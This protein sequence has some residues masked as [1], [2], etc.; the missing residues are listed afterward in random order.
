MVVVRLTLVGRGGTCGPIVAGRL[1]ENP[2]ATVLILEAGKDSADMDN[3]DMA[4][5]CVFNSLPNIHGLPADNAFTI[6]QLDHE[7]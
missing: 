6:V 1:S 5:A 3:M 7:S 4:G 2:N